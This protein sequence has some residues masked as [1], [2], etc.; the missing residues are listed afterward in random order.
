M[1]YL[2]TCTDTLYDGDE[3]GVSY[4]QLDVGKGNV[5]KSSP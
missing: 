3:L 5:S 2:H 1:C 4:G